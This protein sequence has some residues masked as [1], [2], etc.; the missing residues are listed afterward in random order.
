MLRV[1][2]EPLLL[3]SLPFAVY[4]LFVVMFSNSLE[5]GKA[6]SIS[7]VSRLVLA[8]LT[9]ALAGILLFGFEA[10]QHRGIYTPAHIENGQLVPG[11][12]D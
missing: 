8:G 10:E 6:W 12:Q 4:A 3:F 5:P 11:H 1:I 2:G 9:V 7:H